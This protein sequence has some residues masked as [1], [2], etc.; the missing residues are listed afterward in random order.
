MY[1]LM[2]WVMIFAINP[3]MENLPLNGLYWVLA[4]GISYTLGAVLYSISRI[5]FNHA[6]FHLFVLIGT[7]CHFVSVYRYVLPA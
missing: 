7:F 3:M 2:G 5:R 1:V 4:G 6:I